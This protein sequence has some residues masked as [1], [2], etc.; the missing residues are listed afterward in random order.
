VCVQHTCLQA[1]PYTCWHPTVLCVCS[2][3]VLRLLFHPKQLLLVSG[4]DDGEV[5]VWDLVDKA[6]VAH[7]KV[8]EG[9]GVR[10]CMGRRK[11]V[12]A[13]VRQ[14]PFKWVT[15]ARMVCSPCNTITFSPPSLP[16]CRPTFLRSPPWPCPLTGGCC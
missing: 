13:G 16:P 2:G 5:R 6:C 12:C 3:V 8:S 9:A 15:K 4:G 10:A 14:Y 7:L 1:L 11:A